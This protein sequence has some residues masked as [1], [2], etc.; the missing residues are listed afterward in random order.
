MRL[1]HRVGDMPEGSVAASFQALERLEAE[2]LQQ[3]NRAAANQPE[4]VVDGS[5]S[6]SIRG[7]FLRWFLLSA[8]PSATIAFTRLELRNATISGEL[9][10]TGAT[11]KILMRF[12][13]CEFSQTIH[14][15][16]AE[17]RGIDVIGG[18]LEAIFGDRIN[19][20]GSLRLLAPLFGVRRQISVTPAER[21]SSARVGTKIKQ[22]R[23]CGANIR[24]NLDLR[25]SVLGNEFGEKK[26]ARPLF[27]DGAVIGGN[28][29]LSKGFRAVGE[30]CLNGISIGRDLDCSGAT[31][32]NLDGYSLSAAGAKIN[33][34]V[35]LCRQYW[36][37]QYDEVIDSRFTA[38]AFVFDKR[39]SDEIDNVDDLYAIK[40]DGLDVGADLIFGSDSRAREEKICPDLTIYESI[41][42]NK[43]GRF[44]ILGTISLINGRIGG[45]FLLCDTRLH[46]P[47]EDTFCGDGMTVTGHTF[48]DNCY[49]NGVIRF[50][51]ANLKQGLSV[52]NAKFDVTI[53]SRSWDQNSSADDLGGSACGLYAPLAQI[54]S[55]FT[56]KKIEKISQHRNEI[57]F[58][59][60]LSG[61]VI[62]ELA[63]DEESWRALDRLDVTGALYASVS[64]LS[65][66]DYKW[67]LQTLDRQYALLNRHF[68]TDLF[69]LEKFVRQKLRIVKGLFER[70]PDMRGNTVDTDPAQTPNDT[71]LVRRL[72]L[73]EVARRFK[74]QPYLHLAKL[75]RNAGYH[76]AATQVLV[77][78]QRNQTRYSDLGLVRVLWR[79]AVDGA[80]RY[81]HS[82][83]KP[84]VILIIW[85]CVSAIWFERAYDN[86]KLIALR[87]SSPELSETL[88]TQSAPT[89]NSLIYAFDTLLPIVDLNQKKF[90]IVDPLSTNGA[91]LP[92]GST[93]FSEVLFW[94]WQQRPDWMAT[95]LIFNTF[96][97]WLMTTLFVVGVTG[98]MRP[99]DL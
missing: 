92:R 99:K 21:L 45:D 29:L 38:P 25:G 28:V 46:F 71:A 95:L 82:P 37:D 80:I 2:M 50:I 18:R 39:L 53:E 48:L 9:D 62:S 10:L 36:S 26:I 15:T 54:G 51:Q 94:V 93:S 87:F 56:W 27:A 47:G 5:G 59:L 88:R 75:Y 65:G 67:R 20:N 70:K 3:L 30:I 89:F 13:D 17:T 63:D 78:A 58:W 16:D 7:P 81:G 22:I 77:R 72:T 24:G 90:W 14:L 4:L 33:G 96:F 76:S 31:L 66:T 19:V 64:N 6:D 55:T 74:P 42:C 68:Y 12:V 69:V 86:K 49:S 1:V 83:W 43:D 60:D 8:I 84:I 44:D 41:A 97:G 98:L 91:H 57:R 34:T 61:A 85:G 32:V 52:R 23:L 35:M 11:V 79:W 40:A 73:E